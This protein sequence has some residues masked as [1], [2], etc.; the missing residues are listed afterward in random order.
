MM[1]ELKRDI[2][3]PGH[4]YRAGQQQTKEE[5]LQIFPDGFDFDWKDWFIDLSIEETKNNPNLISDLVNEI[6]E[7]KNLHSISYRNA[8]CIYVEQYLKRYR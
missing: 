2:Q 1:F 5:W 6:F 4:Y 8:T 7:A 3:M